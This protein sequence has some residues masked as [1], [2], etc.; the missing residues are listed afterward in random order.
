MTHRAGSSLLSVAGPFFALTVASL[1]AAASVALLLL[2]STAG[3]G[4]TRY[5]P[6]RGSGAST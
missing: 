6:P 2:L 4:L 1:G 3:Y 5:K